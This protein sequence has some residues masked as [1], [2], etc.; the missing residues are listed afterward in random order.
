MS[1]KL[2]TILKKQTKLQ[3]EYNQRLEEVALEIGK[4]FVEDFGI[5]TKA[6]YNRFKKRLEEKGIDDLQALAEPDQKINTVD[7]NKPFQRF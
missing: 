5:E 6:E 2:D 1:Q 4:L 7:D 3:E